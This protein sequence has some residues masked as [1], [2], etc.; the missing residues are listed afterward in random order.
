MRRTLLMVV[1]VLGC[2]QPRYEC[3]ADFA[4]ISACA[5]CDT[6]Q[7]DGGCGS[8]SIVDDAV[9]ICG[10]VEAESATACGVV[11][12]SILDAGASPCTRRSEL[13]LRAGGLDV[14][15]C[16]LSP[17]DGGPVLHGADEPLCRKNRVVEF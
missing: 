3:G 1:V 4:C 2:E 12:G 10:P 14:L 13:A 6:R 5:I 16:A 15:S 8:Q 11:V 17:R 7:A 9:S